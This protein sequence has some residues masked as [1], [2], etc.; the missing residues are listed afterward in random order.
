[1]V[2]SFAGLSRSFAEKDGPSPSA[3]SVILTDLKGYFNFNSGE[4]PKSFRLKAVKPGS[5][6][7]VG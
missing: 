1:M 4:S 3:G 5:F 7:I 6:L 2:F